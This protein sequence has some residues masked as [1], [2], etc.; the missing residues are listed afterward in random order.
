VTQ[1]LLTRH[2]CH[3]VPGD[4][5]VTTEDVPIGPKRMLGRNITALAYCVLSDTEPGVCPVAAMSCNCLGRGAEYKTRDSYEEQTLFSGVADALGA[6]LCYLTRCNTFEGILSH[7][8]QVIYAW[9]AIRLYG[10]I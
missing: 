9:L 8:N 10:H 2:L 5:Q 6:V 3:F 1:R 4:R 7:S